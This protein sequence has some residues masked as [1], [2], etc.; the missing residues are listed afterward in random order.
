MP[1]PSLAG[2]PFEEQPHH[3]YIM[4]YDG[5]SPH[6]GKSSYDGKPSYGGKSSYDEK[7]SYDG[8]SSKIVK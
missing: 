1:G 3:L 7:P 6:D 5:K 2:R 4:N 8:K